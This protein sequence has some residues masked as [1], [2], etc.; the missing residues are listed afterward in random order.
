MKDSHEKI[1][2][3]SITMARSKQCKTLTI[4]I[5]CLIVGGLIALSYT[6]YVKEG[7]ENK[8]SDE[9]ACIKKTLND[10]KLFETIMS[11]R[12]ESNVYG[13]KSGSPN[14]FQNLKKQ[15]TPKQYS[16]FIEVVGKCRT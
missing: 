1:N 6:Q 7:M 9:E 14:F 2:R 13:G 16:D 4:A 8:T 12:N 11:I 3:Y 15:L 5:I 10:P